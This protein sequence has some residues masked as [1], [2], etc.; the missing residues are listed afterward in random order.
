MI[1][2]VIGGQLKFNRKTET[3]VIVDSSLAFQRRRQQRQGGGTSSRSSSNSE[4]AGVS[5]ET[6]TNLVNGREGNVSVP[7]AHP[8]DTLVSIDEE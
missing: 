8:E 3:H 4:S 1:L 7:K 5:S 6:F 2:T